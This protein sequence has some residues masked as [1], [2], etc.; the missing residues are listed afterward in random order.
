MVKLIRKKI[1]E[2]TNVPMWFESK[3]GEIVATMVGSQGDTRIRI[4]TP[5]KCQEY[6]IVGANFE[7]LSKDPERVKAIIKRRLKELM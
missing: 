3:N 7:K 2:D 5:K 4:S 1:Q 6:G